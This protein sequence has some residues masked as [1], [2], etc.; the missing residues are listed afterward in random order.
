MEKTSDVRL[1]LAE[2]VSKADSD[3]AFHARLKANPSAV[4]K[5][6]GI[7]ENAVEALSRA[8][9][10]RQANAAGLA[11]DPTECIHTNGCRDFTCWSS[12]CPNSC[13]ASFVMD[14]PDA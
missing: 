8:N 10:E 5:E 3:P 2:V 6:Y 9:S 11:D 4:L 7:A 13:Y 12:G 1:R 14:A